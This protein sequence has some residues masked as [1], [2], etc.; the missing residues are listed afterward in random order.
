M[1]EGLPDP[2]VRMDFPPAEYPHGYCEDEHGNQFELPLQ[3][4]QS[5]MRP[6]GPCLPIG[7][8]DAIR[9]A[10]PSDVHSRGAEGHRASP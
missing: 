8:W 6:V 2:A 5:G 9:R 3:R 1:A 4:Y 10:K 7:T